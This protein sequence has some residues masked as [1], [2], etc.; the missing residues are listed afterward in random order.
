MSRAYSETETQKLI[1]SYSE[2]PCIE[3]VRKLAV[4][5]NRPQKSII[6]KLASEGVYVTRGYTDYAGEKPI[7]KIELV[8]QV[9][10]ALDITVPGLDKC[11]KQ[12]L[13]KLTRAITDLAHH[14]DQALD[15]IADLSENARIREDMKSSKSSKSSDEITILL[16]GDSKSS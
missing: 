6:A 16:E 13:K 9:E 2:N 8:R 3:T 11:P 5:F 1:D 12:S 14:F 15:E 4:K 7:T 10:D